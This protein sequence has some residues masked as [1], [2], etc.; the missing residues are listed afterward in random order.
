MEPSPSL[1]N[2]KSLTKL[3]RRSTI[4]GFRR[5][6]GFNSFSFK[7]GQTVKIDLGLT[8]KEFQRFRLGPNCIW[9]GLIG[10]SVEPKTADLPTDSFLD[11]TD[12]AVV[13]RTR[14]RV[15][16]Q[17]IHFSA[18]SSYPAINAATSS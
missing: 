7:E 8:D 14:H 16:F 13:S 1:T 12:R 2:T 6:E 17:T 18:V 15:Q 3:R 4:R 10:F 11:W 9:V 5:H